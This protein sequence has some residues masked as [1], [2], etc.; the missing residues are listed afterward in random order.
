MAPAEWILS[1]DFGT[2]NTAAAHSAAVS[3]AIESLALSHAGNLMSSG[4]FVDA[5]DRIAVGDHAVNEAQR[6]PAAFI[7]APKRLVGQDSIAVNGHLVGTSLPIG[8]VLRTVFSRAAAAHAGRM[9]SHLVLTHPEAWSPAQV[10]VL[11]DAAGWAGMNPAAITT[12][13]EPRA[14]AAHY[15]RG[16]DLAVGAT[17]AVFDFGG[18]TLDVAVLIRDTDGGFSVIAARGDNGLGGKNFDA[19]I[20]R[21]VDHQ[22]EAR[23]PD[24]AHYLRRTAPAGVRHQLDESIRRAKELLSEAPS[25]TI[26]AAGGGFHETLQITRDEFDELIAAPLDAAAALTRAVL[27]DAGIRSR[28]QLTALYLTGGTSRIPLVQRTLQTLGPVATL[29]DPKTVV[30]QGA[31]AAVISDRPRQAVLPDAAD[32]MSQWKAVPTGPT[33]AIAADTARTGPTPTPG[34]TETAGGSSPRRGRRALLAGAASVVVVAAVVAAVV[35]LTS[36]GSDDPAPNPSAEST[37][38]VAMTGLRETTPEG[39]VARLPQKLASALTGCEQANDGPSGIPQITC[40]ISTDSGLVTGLL[41]PGARITV[42][43]DRTQARTDVVRIRRGDSGGTTTVVENT[44]RT[45]AA[46][47]DQSPGGTAD[48]TYANSG[49]Y[50]RAFV[51]GVVGTNE[52]KTF[53]TRS[54]LIS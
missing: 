31:L 5:P 7:P 40:A 33:A 19:L 12:I 23:N 51:S 30:A 53:L 15:A 24:L 28:D 45:A 2:S 22:L 49:S 6:N 20:R 27:H 43:A 44:A 41:T 47:V 48:I 37:G 3:G 13:S 39:I 34:R 42:S 11:L 10:R 32:L 46:G 16:T 38:S 52:A 8:A 26:T 36:G 21:W 29:D 54:E 4:V 25:A 17:I 50:I 35:V 1:V 14:A 18:G 9:P